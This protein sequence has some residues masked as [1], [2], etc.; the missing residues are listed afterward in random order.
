MEREFFYSVLALTIICTE[1]K[2]FTM[3]E[4]KNRDIQVVGEQPRVAGD[5]LI[6]Y[7]TGKENLRYV[8]N[9]QE[10]V[11][12]G[13]YLQ[14]PVG[15]LTPEQ[16]VYLFE[17]NLNCK[18][19]LAPGTVSIRPWEVDGNVFDYRFSRSGDKETNLRPM[20]AMQ[21]HALTVIRSCCD[22]NICQEKCFA[23]TSKLIAFYIVDADRQQVI[24]R[25]RCMYCALRSC[26]TTCKNGMFATDF[27]ATDSVMQKT[28]PQF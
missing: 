23:M 12:K 21:Q 15:T 2:L 6:P 13:I 19:I 8:L 24:L 18:D 20:D 5:I 11:L 3:T 10:N 27:T 4:Q 9:W 16:I 22:P 25:G 26:I 14:E 7:G 17:G 28:S 1:C